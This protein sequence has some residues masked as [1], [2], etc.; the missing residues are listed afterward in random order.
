MSRKILGWLVGARDGKFWDLKKIRNHEKNSRKHQ[1]M[2]NTKFLPQP[3]PT[4][5]DQY[6]QQYPT[7]TTTNIKIQPKSLLPP[8]PNVP[9]LSVCKCSVG[10]FV[11]LVVVVVGKRR[12]TI[13]TITITIT[14]TTNSYTTN[15][16][17]NTTNTTP[18]LTV[19]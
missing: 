13:I 6:H 3:P 14:T 16:P 4:P 19:K 5:I 8:S 18:K 12:S 15:I 1:E 9:Y 10:I 7:F 17:T 11:V 2:V